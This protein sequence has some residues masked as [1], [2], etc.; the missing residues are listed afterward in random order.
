L[1]V[2]HLLGDGRARV[3]NK[4]LARPRRADR[5]RP[6]CPPQQPSNTISEFAL[7]AFAAG[8]VVIAGAHFIA[9]LL[10]GFVGLPD[11]ATAVLTIILMVGLSVLAGFWADSALSLFRRELAIFRRDRF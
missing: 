3:I 1:Y 8:T 4:V 11:G 5:E 6:A 9:S 7:Y 10:S 2:E